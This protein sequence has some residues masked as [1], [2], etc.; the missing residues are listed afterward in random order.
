ME[1]IANIIR[2]SLILHPYDVS[3]VG[4]T[5]EKAGFS[6]SPM[7][8]CKDGYV[9]ISLSQERWWKTLIDA[10]GAPPELKGPDYADAGARPPE[11]HG[12]R[13]IDHVLVHGVHKREELYD[14][15]IP[16]HLPCFPVNSMREVTGSPQYAA[17]EYFATQ[18]HPVAG[19]VT[20]PR[21]RHPNGRCRTPASL[22][23][24]DAR[25]E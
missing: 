12:P 14:I 10:P 4:R 11:C 20:H 13:S 9:S 1:A 23:G 16:L 6:A 2:G 5:R 3:R 17:R 22:A 7:F 24:A 25:R 18:D 19:A 21:T 8:Q 15:F